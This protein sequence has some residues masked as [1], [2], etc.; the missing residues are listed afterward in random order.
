MPPRDRHIFQA[1]SNER[2]VSLLAEADGQSTDWEVTALFYSALHYVDALLDSTAG[3]HPR[4]HRNRNI[5]VSRHTDIARYYLRLYNWSLD[6]RYN[7]VSI[8]PEE[9]ERIADDYFRPIRENI[10][11]EL[12]LS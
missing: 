4:N 10:R 8:L 12:N 7:V 11:N 6:T 9:V 2:V 1:E 5:L 3:L